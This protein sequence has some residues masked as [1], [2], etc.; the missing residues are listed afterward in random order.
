METDRNY[1]QITPGPWEWVFLGNAGNYFL[2]GNEGNG[3]I[4]HSGPDSAD[5]NLKRAAPDLLAACEASHIAMIAMG[6]HLNWDDVPQSYVDAINTVRAAI[7]K[8]R[9]N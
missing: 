7:A 8:A 6:N 5:G 4:T 1:E 2:L 3:P 9:G